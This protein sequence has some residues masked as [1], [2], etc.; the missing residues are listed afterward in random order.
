[1]ATVD[2]HIRYIERGS[3]KLSIRYQ[4][5]GPTTS[6]L[7]WKVAFGREATILGLPADNIDAETL[8]YFWESGTHY[9]SAAKDVFM[10]S[11]YH[12]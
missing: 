7:E 12:Y 8:R 1:M 5:G 10:S 9:A 11:K 6:L 3:R 4:D 2:E